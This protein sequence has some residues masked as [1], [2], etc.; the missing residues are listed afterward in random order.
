M[1]LPTV[2]ARWIEIRPIFN[3]WIHGGKMGQFQGHYIARKLFKYNNEN[4][5]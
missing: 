2:P 5:K 1:S 4:K 3:Q